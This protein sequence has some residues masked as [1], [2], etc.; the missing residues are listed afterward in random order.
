MISNNRI[1]ILLLLSIQ[2][3]IAPGQKDQRLWVHDDM[4]SQELRPHCGDICCE[5]GSWAL[6]ACACWLVGTSCYSYWL[7][8]VLPH[9][10]SSVDKKLEKAAPAPSLMGNS[11]IDGQ[12]GYATVSGKKQ[13]QLLKKRQ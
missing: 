6:I 9:D 2:G 11:K 5:C 4:S 10:N 3:V 12:K 13:A 8:T 7:P 1:W